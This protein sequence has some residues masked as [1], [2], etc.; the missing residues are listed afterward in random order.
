MMLP[1]SLVQF[2]IRVRT[3][4]VDSHAIR[5]TYQDGVLGR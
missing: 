3:L 1:K 5:I 2:R 4:R